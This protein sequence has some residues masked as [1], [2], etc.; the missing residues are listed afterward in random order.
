MMEDTRRLAEYRSIE[1]HPC[2]NCLPELASAEG[3]T[4]KNATAVIFCNLS[5]VEL[6][7]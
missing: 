2:T 1:S 6:P 7:P 4:E 3:V 5:H